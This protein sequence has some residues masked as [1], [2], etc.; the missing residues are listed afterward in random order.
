MI[1]SLTSHL[2]RCLTLDENIDCM[3]VRIAITLAAIPSG[4]RKVP[5]RHLQLRRQVS[6]LQ[7]RLL[8]YLERGFLEVIAGLMRRSI[9]KYACKPATDYKSGAR[10]MAWL[11]GMGVLSF[12]I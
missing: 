12:I 1:N 2:L 6:S 10:M 3:D 7:V 9:I 5:S 4:K 11:D 8:F